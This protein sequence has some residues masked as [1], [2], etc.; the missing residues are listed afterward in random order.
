MT[1]RRALPRDALLFQTHVALRAQP[2]ERV[3]LGGSE[4][5]QHRG[6]R[7]E[8]FWPG[9]SAQLAALTSS[10]S[11]QSEFTAAEGA[12]GQCEPLAR[13]MTAQRMFDWLESKLAS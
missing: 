4:P 6:V 11:T 7:A 9:Q 10:V 2:T 1:L 5:I 12:A 3:A 13:A 8:Q